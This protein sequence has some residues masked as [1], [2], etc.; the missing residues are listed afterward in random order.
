MFTMVIRYLAYCWTNRST[1]DHISELSY[2][3]L[4]RFTA[5]DFHKL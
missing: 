4:T 2:I 5:D 1:I 3:L